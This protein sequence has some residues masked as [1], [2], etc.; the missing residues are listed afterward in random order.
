MMQSVVAIIAPGSMGS[1]VGRRLVDH[2]IKVVTPVAGRSEA[3]K[4]RARDAGM[5]AVPEAEIAASE[6]VLSIVPPGEALA[7]AERLAPLLAQ[8]QHKPIFVDCNAINP[9]TAARVAAVVTRAGLRFVDAG[10]IGG[11][12]SP[13]TAGPTFYASGADAPRF[14]A[15]APYGLD[16][17]VLDGPP[18]AASALKMSYAGITKGFTALG[19]AMMLAATRGGAAQALRSELAHSQPALFAWLN[20]QVPKMYPKAYR[21]VAEMEEIAG[22]VGDDPAARQMFEGAARLYERLAEDGGSAQQETAALSAFLAGDQSGLQ[23][24]HERHDIPGGANK[25]A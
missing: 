2:G 1:A 16:I 24:V 22:Y 20:R 3:S 8:G 11:P 5:A 15:L 23:P 19:A 7:L 25:V 21:F 9:A 17:R 13:Q 6:M 12:P 18:G 4:A 10:I 14:A